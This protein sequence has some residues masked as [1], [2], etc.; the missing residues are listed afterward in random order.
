MLRAAMGCARPDS[1]WTGKASALQFNSPPSDQN[2]RS[3]DATG[4][5]FTNHRDQHEHGLRIKEDQRIS[6]S[7]GNVEGQVRAEDVV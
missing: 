5:T 2:S 1:E 3:G 7:Q 4:S 6:N